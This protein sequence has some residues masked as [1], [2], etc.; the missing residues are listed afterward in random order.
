MQK[1][2]GLIKELAE[3]SSHDINPEGQLYS[4]YIDTIDEVSSYKIQ[5][6]KISIPMIDTIG[7]FKALS[8][9]LIWLIFAILGFLGKFGE[10]NRMIGGIFFFLVAILFGW[11]GILIPVIW[12]PWV[13]FIGFPIVQLVI[14]L[15]LGK[16]AGKS[17][18][19]KSLKDS[20]Q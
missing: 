9:G 14:I 18:N 7:L 20:S 11:I 15:W 2:I 12:N 5:P 8:G 6:F 19:K 17:K 16:L 10:N 4:V 13:N 1:K 3:I